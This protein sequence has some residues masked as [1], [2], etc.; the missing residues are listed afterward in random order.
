MA[1]IRTFRG[2]RRRVFL[3]LTRHA[4]QFDKLTVPSRLEGRLTFHAFS[5]SRRAAVCLISTCISMQ[6]R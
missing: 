3:P 1:T 5:G 2:A 6:P 4:L